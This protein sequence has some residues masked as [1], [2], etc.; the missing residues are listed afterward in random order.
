MKEKLGVK[1]RQMENIH[2]EDQNEIMN[3]RSLF[4]I[5]KTYVPTMEELIWNNRV[6]SLRQLIIVLQVASLIQLLLQN[7]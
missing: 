4:A 6:Y 7:D 1:K 3:R 2:T 5:S